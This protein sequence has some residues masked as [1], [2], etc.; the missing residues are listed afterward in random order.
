MQQNKQKDKIFFLIIFIVTGIV[1]AIIASLIEKKIENNQE[2]KVTNKENANVISKTRTENDEDI[3]EIGNYI[4][5]EYTENEEEMSNNE[6]TQ[7]KNEKLINETELNTYFLIKKCMKQY[8]DKNDD[9]C[10]DK[11]LKQKLSK[12]ENLF[13][14]YY[15]LNTEKKEL[16]LK[17]NIDNNLATIYSAEYL[18]EKKLIGKA[19]GDTVIL[20]D[21]S[22][23][24]SFSCKINTTGIKNQ[25]TVKELF[26]RYKFDL[27]YDIEHL[28]SIIED[29]YKKERF[30]NLQKFNNF[31]ESEFEELYNDK[32][33]KYKVNDYEESIQYTAICESNKHYI[34]NMKDIMNYSVCLDNYTVVIQQYLDIYEYA[35]PEVQAKY[36]INRIEKAIEDKNYEFV[37]EK[38]NPILKNNYYPNYD[39]FEQFMKNNFF[40][41]N[42]FEYKKY[43]TI[44]P[45]SYQYYV[46]VKDKS[47]KAIY[48][49]RFKIAVTLKENADFLVSIVPNT[50]I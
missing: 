37:Y 22:G 8:I 28:Y 25:V 32:L 48:F 20:E 45:S 16:I 10:I 47:K 15:R 11:I 24:E 4:R 50:E 3:N 13:V 34:F 2:Q 6:D 26:F 31:I 1:V 23:Y 33:I 14:V 17:Y 43:I 30:S 42:E 39:D 35:F 5:N 9:F 38:L 29:D 7:N 18:K 36:C 44:T 27:K 41:K 46:N 21:D 19:E 49:K 40:N 12:K